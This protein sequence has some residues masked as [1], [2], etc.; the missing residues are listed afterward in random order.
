MMPYLCQYINSILNNVVASKYES[1]ETENLHLSMVL[2]I[3]EQPNGKW[4]SAKGT[5]LLEP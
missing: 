3:E 2:L 4:Q 1:G 5:Y